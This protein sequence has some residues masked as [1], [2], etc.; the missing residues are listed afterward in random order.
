VLRP[1]GHVGFSDL[2]LRGCPSQQEDDALRAVLYHRGAELV[3]DWPALFVRHGF[4]IVDRRDIITDT[5]ETWDRV[6]VVYEQR[7]SRPSTVTATGS[8]AESARRST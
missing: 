8:P 4:T 1:G 5:I 2:A 3:T 7:T 6:R